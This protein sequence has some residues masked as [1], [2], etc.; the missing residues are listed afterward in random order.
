V[1]ERVNQGNPTGLVQELEA[2]N[3]YVQFD[4]R[5]VETEWDRDLNHRATPRLY[6]FIFF[7]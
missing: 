6:N 2:G 3:P 7:P 4:E 5:A 1:G